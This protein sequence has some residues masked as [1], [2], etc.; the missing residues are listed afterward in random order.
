MV[1][2]SKSEDYFCFY[3][4]MAKEL[5]KSY[6]MYFNNVDSNVQ[7]KTELLDGLIA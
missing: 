1:P 4:K 5:P 7:P 3:L 2:Y 6:K